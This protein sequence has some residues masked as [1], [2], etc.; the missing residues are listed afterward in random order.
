[1]AAASSFCLSPCSLPPST[2]ARIYSSDYIV[3]ASPAGEPLGAVHMD[4]IRHIYLHY[5]I[6]P[7][8]YARAQAME[9]LQPL[10]RAVQDAPLE[11][12]YKTEIVPLITE[13][14]IKAIETH[15]MDVGLPKPQRPTAVKAA[16][17]SRT[18]RRRDERL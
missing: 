4:D 16:R 3:V 6:E 11:Y 14:L 8:V 15:T 17:R 9:R 12:I 2:N 1:M 13:C 18:L 5:E 10:L 7:L